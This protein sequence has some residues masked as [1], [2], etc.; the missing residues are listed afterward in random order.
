MQGHFLL[1]NFDNHPAADA[2]QT[3]EEGQYPGCSASDASSTACW[4]AGKAYNTF[5]GLSDFSHD[6]GESCSES[7]SDAGSSD[8]DSDVSID[9]MIANMEDGLSLME[10]YPVLLNEKPPTSTAQGQ[11]MLQP[12]MKLFQQQEPHIIAIVLHTRRCA[13]TVFPAFQRIHT[14]VVVARHTMHSDCA[15]VVQWSC[16]H[17]SKLQLQTEA[18]MCCQ[19]CKQW[20]AASWGEEAFEAGKDASEE[21]ITLRSAGP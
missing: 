18:A 8:N 13:A 2:V 20:Q 11:S 12:Q 7:Q 6:S 4:L 14:N 16:L 19:R 21:G 10:R 1:A 17:R 9:D 3:A 5:A 15:T